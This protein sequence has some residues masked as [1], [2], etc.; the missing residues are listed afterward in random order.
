MVNKNLKQWLASE[1]SDQIGFK[2]SFNAETI[3]T[4]VAFA[5]RKGGT[6]LP[7]ANKKQ[8]A[9]LTFPPESAQQWINEVKEKTGPPLVPDATILG[10]KKTGGTG[11]YVAPQ[12]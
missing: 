5:N 1:V 12:F 2:S 10:N 11:G 6:V 9:D 8:V 4:L 3:K 7:R